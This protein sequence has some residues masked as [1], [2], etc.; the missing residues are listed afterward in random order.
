MSQDSVHKP[1]PFWRERRA[2]AVSNRGPSSYQPNALPLGQTDPLLTKSLLASI[3]L[4]KERLWLSH[5]TGSLLYVGP[6]GLHWTT[7][8]GDGGNEKLTSFYLVPVDVL[9]RAAAH[10]AG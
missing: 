7:V 10:M 3:I 4:S 6:S 8:A 5:W 2:E 1:P 9:S